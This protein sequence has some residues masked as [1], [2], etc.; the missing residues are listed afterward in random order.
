MDDARLAET[1]DYV[2]IRRL[3]SAYADVCTR[4]AWAELDGLF[5]PDALVE[6][7]RRVGEPMRFVGP[8]AIGDFIGDAISGMDFFEFVVLNTRVE[9]AVGG[10]PDVACA[11]MYMQ[12]LRHETDSGRFTIVYGVYHDRLARAGGHWWFEHRRYHTLTRSA[13]PDAAD[14]GEWD[15]FESPHHLRLEQL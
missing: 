10:D 1:V 7:D 13:G 3:Q 12:E 8:R 2:A 9:L 5:L 15:V 4:R 11:R 14:D 6:V